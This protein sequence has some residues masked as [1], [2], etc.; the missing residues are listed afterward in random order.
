MNEQ[1]QPA[2]WDLGPHDAAIIFGDIKGYSKL[3]PSQLRIFFET[4]LPELNQI[5]SRYKP[6]V[7]NTWGDAVVATFHGTREAAYCAVALRDYFKDTIWSNRG[8]PNLQIRISLHRGPVWKVMDPI[9]ESTNV[10]GRHVNLAARLEP[11]TEPNQIWTT[12]EFLD[13]LDITQCSD[14]ELT[15]EDLGERPLAKDFG[16]KGL[17]RLQK[18]TDAPEK[19]PSRIESAHVKLSPIFPTYPTHLAVICVRNYLAATLRIK[20]MKDRIPKTVRSVF[21]LYGDADLLL[22][23]SL[24]PNDSVKIAV[25]TFVDLMGLGKQLRTISLDGSFES[26]GATRGEKRRATAGYVE[27]ERPTTFAGVIVN[28]SGGLEEAETWYPQFTGNRDLVVAHV[29]LEGDAREARD[30][31]SH[32]MSIQE[33]ASQERVRSFVFSAFTLRNKGVWMIC[34]FPTRRYY[35]FTELTKTIDQLCKTLG[36]G[37]AVNTTLVAEVLHWPDSP[38]EIA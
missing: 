21:G 17:Y 28:S 30:L 23:L 20:Q 1:A 2:N 37:L 5:L 3:N 38:P 4:V 8:L 25:D 22:E 34:L 31:I 9:R 13:A 32:L 10:F 33:K 26:V 27:I 7:K 19:A 16:A 12:D 24:P 18:K 35:E 36:Y 14:P 15:V 29:A 11:V 6:F